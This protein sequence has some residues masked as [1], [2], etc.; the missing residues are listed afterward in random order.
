MAGGQLTEEGGDI[1]TGRTRTVDTGAAIIVAGST[2]QG[3]GE[4]EGEEG[5]WHRQ[6]SWPSP[7]STSAIVAAV[8]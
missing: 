3:E 5:G 7:S 8:D 4:G 6:S 1:I 2:P